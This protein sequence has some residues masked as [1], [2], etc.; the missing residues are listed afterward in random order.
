MHAARTSP[1][2]GPDEIAALHELRAAIDR[3]IDTLTPREALVVRRYYGL[4]GDGCTYGELGQQLG[5]SGGRI[6]Q[7][8]FKALRKLRHPSRCRI[9]L[10]HIE[11]ET[12][13]ELQT[14]EEAAARAAER[15]AEEAE[16]AIRI[17]ELR[18]EA[19]E[20]RDRD[21]RRRRIGDEIGSS[22][23]WWSD[24]RRQDIAAALDRVTSEV[25]TELRSRDDVYFF[26]RDHFAVS[27]RVYEAWKRD[28]RRRSPDNHV[29][30]TCGAMADGRQLIYARKDQCTWY[31]F[32]IH[33]VRGGGAYRWVGY[34]SV[35]EAVRQGRSRALE[36]SMYLRIE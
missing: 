4:E 2:P 35:D 21:N 30:F 17:E 33:P 29:T 7:I 27:W 32:G 36:Q 9:L 28:V 23:S 22:D 8:I 1:V 34:A 19:E 18:Q 10:P 3:M 12:Y 16:E 6:N 14:A 5:I 24:E 31:L 26:I 13:R 20:R 25:V 11:L 15:E